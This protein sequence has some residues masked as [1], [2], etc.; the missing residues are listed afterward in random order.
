MVNISLIIESLIFSFDQ[1]VC[2]IELW[3]ELPFFLRVW[4][5]LASPDNGV[6]VWRFRHGGQDTV[7]TVSQLKRQTHTHHLPSNYTT[8]RDIQIRWKCIEAYI[9]TLKR[10]PC[11]GTVKICVVSG[12]RFWQISICERHGCIVRDEIKGNQA[13]RKFFLKTFGEQ[14]HMITTYY[15]QVHTQRRQSSLKTFYLG[16]EDFWV[17]RLEI[18]VC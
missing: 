16:I 1:C 11:T 8:W 14:Y 3:F 5:L 4:V 10:N 2:Y 6:L 12:C 15:L 17:Q 9:F 7:I 18:L 13:Y